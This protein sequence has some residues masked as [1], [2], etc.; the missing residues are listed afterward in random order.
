MKQVC[1]C[2]NHPFILAVK[3][4][5]LVSQ[6]K[7]WGTKSA[8][9][10]LGKMWLKVQPKLKSGLSCLTHA[11]QVG[12]PK[13][14]P[15]HSTRFPPQEFYCSSTAVESME[16]KEGTKKKL[17]KKHWFTQFRLLKPLASYWGSCKCWDKDSGV[18][19]ISATGNTFLFSKVSRNDYREI[20]DKLALMSIWFTWPFFQETCLIWSSC[21]ANHVCLW[22]RTIILW[23]YFLSSQVEAKNTPNEM[24]ELFLVSFLQTIEKYETADTHSTTAY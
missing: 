2:W 14:Q 17:Q 11:N 3:R 9:P 23:S 7:W 20:K 24:L 10:V 6:C 5:H 4:F 15:Q 1:A 18:S 21:G 13:L 22:P 16:N 12:I 19:L 8:V